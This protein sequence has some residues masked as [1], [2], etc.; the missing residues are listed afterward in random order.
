MA[1]SPSRSRAAPA[2]APAAPDKLQP[3][4]E[5]AASGATIEPTIVDRVD[6]KHPAVDD[7]PRA[8]T[9]AVQNRIDFN[10]PTIS[11]QEAVERN[12][13]AQK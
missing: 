8:G 1:R 7:E 6:M 9:T 10:D 3:A 12:L 5:F 11:G 4:Q 2:T 13:K